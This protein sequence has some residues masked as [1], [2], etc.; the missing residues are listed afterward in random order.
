MTDYTQM[1]MAALLPGMQYMIEL[2]QA[3]LDEMR[4]KL[5][6]LQGIAEPEKKK[7]N[8]YKAYWD[9]MT[10]KQ[11]ADRLARM[12]AGKL[13]AARLRKQAA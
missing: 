11:K 2:M 10:R 4:I 9:R 3:Q 5:A 13:K 1:G 12:Q 6:A 7:V 8:G